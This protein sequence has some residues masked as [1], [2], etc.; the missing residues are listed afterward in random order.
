MNTE[1]NQ[2]LKKV[3]KAQ[4]VHQVNIPCVRG[5]ASPGDLHDG[6]DCHRVREHSAMD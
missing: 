3:A 5:E 6:L 4:V 2:H 1:Y